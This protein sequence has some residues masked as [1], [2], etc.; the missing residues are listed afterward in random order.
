MAHVNFVNSCTAKGQFRHRLLYTG[1][2]HNLKDTL[3][4]FTRLPVIGPKLQLRDEQ[5]VEMYV[6]LT[7]WMK[8]AADLEIVQPDRANAPPRR[9]LAFE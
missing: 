4:P 5:G 2:S 8:L 1:I 6:A 3:Q 7:G 9:S